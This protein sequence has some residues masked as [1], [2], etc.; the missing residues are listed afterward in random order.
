MIVRS[1]QRLDCLSCFLSL[2]KWDTT[3]QMVYNVVID[4]LVEEMPTD[5]TSS[6][7]NGGQRTLGIGPGLG[8]VMRHIRMGML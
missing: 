4:D 6:T 2:I 3:E 8:R 1:Q 5:E 7:V